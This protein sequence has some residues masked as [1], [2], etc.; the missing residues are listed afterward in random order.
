M[1]EA[2]K[3]LGTDT[4]R[5]M[6][7]KVNKS[8]DNANVALTKSTTA[9]SKS[10]SAVNTAKTAETKADNVQAQFNQ[11]VIDGD[12]SVEAAQAR[13]RAD[14]TTFSTLRDRMNDTDEQ[15]AQ[16]EKVERKRISLEQFSNLINGDDWTE[17]L[18]EGVGFSS[19]N[20]LILVL[21]NEPIKISHIMFSQTANIFI[22]F[23]PNSILKPIN[24]LESDFLVFK[25]CTNVEILD[26]R[27]DGENHYTRGLM[28]LE[29]NR[30]VNINKIDIK[31]ISPIIQEAA[32]NTNGVGLFIATHNNH[33]FNIGEVFVDGVRNN[34]N[35][36]IG[37]ALGS[38]RGIL[39]DK[40]GESQSISCTNI[41]I[42]NV[43]IKNI[44]AEDG[45]GIQFAGTP[46]KHDIIIDTVYTDNTERR[47]LKFQ[48]IKG[49]KVN[50]LVARQTDRSFIMVAGVSMYTAGNEV[51][52]YDIDV[53][54]TK[55][56]E[57]APT[58][59]SDVKTIFKSGN[60][61]LSNEKTLD[62]S[63]T[64]PFDIR[65]QPNTAVR[66]LLI[67]NL[68]SKG[69][70]SGMFIR[71]YTRDVVI[72]SAEH[73][74]YTK[75]QVTVQFLKPATASPDGNAIHHINLKLDN[76]IGELAPAY[77]AAEVTFANS[78]F[79]NHYSKNGGNPYSLIVYHKGIK[80]T[81]NDFYSDAIPTNGTYPIGTYI[82][83][84][85]CRLQWD[86]V[87]TKSKIIKG[88][89]R[90]TEG[91]THI[92]GTDWIEDRIIVE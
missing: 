61:L 85:R 23:L 90:V 64:I 26:Y 51:L 54:A 92:L 6:Y 13:V 34:N 15:L 52:E 74:S 7:P 50:K 41:R 37:D 80:V 35:G 48:D 76:V 8:I 17:A 30:N 14:G 53:R 22:E 21:P 62:G 44:Y 47:A 91:N 40:V 71:A 20:G 4:L 43:Q 88:W 60:I 29:G 57:F 81:K 82:I 49:V 78:S 66:N 42:G 70:N 45:D 72:K 79:D 16:R 18:K 12:S 32:T 19:A 3:I 28:F 77:P 1:A 2:P 56:V 69:P 86:S 25:D 58:D 68:I 73:T 33:N 87:L 84:S 67:E 11:I 65:E 31:N 63:T 55:G 36:V 10:T 38:T 59:T 24:G 83:N 89:I 5:Q 9:E 27:A 39:F 75:D 46:I